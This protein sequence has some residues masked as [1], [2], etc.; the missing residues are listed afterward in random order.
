MSKEVNG[1]FPFNRKTIRSKEFQ[2]LPECAK[3]LYRCLCDLWNEYRNNL[4]QMGRFTQSD[5]ELMKKFH[6]GIDGIKR[7]R[8]SLMDVGLICFWVGCPGH[9][10]KYRVEDGEYIKGVF[11]PA[12]S[13]S[14]NKGGSTAPIKPGNMGG[15]LHPY[16]G[17]Q[18]HPCDN[19]K[20]SP[21]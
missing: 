14:F 21:F 18:L 12:S 13:F 9:K 15:Q 4:D 5:Q 16:M 2:S 3:D 20:D 8:K 17:G 19:P 11:H 6:L 7:G 10:S 1:Y